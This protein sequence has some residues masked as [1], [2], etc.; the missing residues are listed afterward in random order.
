MR[1]LFSIGYSTS[2]FNIAALI[3]R[4]GSG[5][6]M[7]PHGYDKLVKFKTMSPNFMPFLGMSPE[8]SLALVVFAEF[9]CSILVILGLMTRFACIPLIIDTFVALA[10]GHDFDLFGKGEHA[11]LFLTIFLALLFVGPGRVSVDGMIK[12]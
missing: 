11:A 9:F 7:L 1:K 4:L 5:A 10:K 8:I 6:L 12:K 3:L 2:A